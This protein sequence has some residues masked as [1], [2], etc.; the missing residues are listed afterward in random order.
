[1]DRQDRR[2]GSCHF[3]QLGGTRAYIKVDGA[4]IAFTRKSIDL[5]HG[6][7]D[8]VT[9]AIQRGVTVHGLVVDS[10]GAP[11]EDASVTCFPLDRS[12]PPV[13]VLTNELGEFSFNDLPW[14]NYEVRGAR[15]DRGDGTIS[16]VTPSEVPYR[17]V[18]SPRASVKLSVSGSDGRTCESYSVTISRAKSSRTVPGAFYRKEMIAADRVDNGVAIVENVA[19]DD[20]IF[21]IRAPGH[22]PAITDS[23]LVRRA[24]VR[25]TISVQLEAAPAVYGYVIDGESGLGITADLRVMDSEDAASPMSSEKLRKLL[26]IERDEELFRSDGSGR[27]YFRPSIDVG[28]VAIS[29]L[30]YPR[31]FIDIDNHGKSDRDLGRV[32]LDRGVKAAGSVTVS[33]E[34]PNEKIDVV[35]QRDGTKK[36]ALRIRAGVGGRLTLKRRLAAGWYT[37][38]AARVAR[39]PFGG[40]ADMK[41]SSIRLRVDRTRTEDI[42]FA[43]NIP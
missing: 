4:N 42:V 34:V 20:Y 40:Y 14:N 32:V 2:Q 28:Y 38:R 6:R 7:S 35:I 1:M 22:R 25:D 30:D 16:D 12:S 36:F 39:G 33:G 13:R 9:V 31:K 8:E 3:D 41:A 18:V 19:D 23:I 43:I 15:R 26:G 27:F 37:L 11:L 24:V 21:E 29:Y 10:G 17:L 5:E